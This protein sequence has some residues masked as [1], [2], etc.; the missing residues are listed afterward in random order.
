MSGSID[1]DVDVFTWREVSSSDGL[2][3]QIQALFWL[4]KHWAQ[5]SH[6]IDTALGCLVT[7]TTYESIKQH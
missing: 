4:V 7:S 3:Q 1:G 5:R 6:F 2:H